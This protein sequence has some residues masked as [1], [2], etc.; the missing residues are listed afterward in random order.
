MEPLLHGNYYHIYN[1]G[2]NSE[3][4]FIDKDNYE[5]FIRLFNKYIQPICETYSWCLMPNHFH[6]LLRIKEVEEINKEELPIPVRLA[7]SVR[8]VNPD[9]VE[10]EIKSPHLYFSH[11]FNAYTQAFNK[12]S[13][14]HGNLFERPFKRILVQDESYFKQLILYIHNNPVKHGFTSTAGE[15]SWSTY[16]EIISSKPTNISR[17]KTIGLFNDHANFIFCHRNIFESTD[18]ADLFLE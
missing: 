1:R 4:L 14:R 11:L 12:Y 7:N 13:S 6:F 8:V 16:N 5:Y 10:A 17:D 15:Y 3:N 9:R 18:A 2:I